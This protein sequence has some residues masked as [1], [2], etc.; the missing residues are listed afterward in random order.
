MNIDKYKNPDGSYEDPEGATHE[1]AESFLQSHVL[2][3]C[4]CG[5]PDLSLAYTREVLQYILDLRLVWEE[6]QTYEEWIAS[7]KN[8]FASDG[9]RYF[10]FYVLDSKGLTEHGGSVPGWLSEKGMDLL[11]DLNEMANTKTPSQL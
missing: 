1:D 6:K 7:G 11:S 2:E 10:V 9:A 4:G 3:F 8:L 5:S